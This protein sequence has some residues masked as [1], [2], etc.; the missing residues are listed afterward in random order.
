[1]TLTALEKLALSNIEPSKEERQSIAPGKHKVAFTVTVNGVL[2]VSAPESYIPTVDVP[3]IPTVA[4]ALKK[5]GVQRENFLAIMKESMTEVLACDKAMRV[6]LVA[7]SG[8]IDFEK[9]FRKTLGKLP[10][11]TRVGKVN[12]KLKATPKTDKVW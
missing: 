3:L 1:M 5:M 7:E 11:K 12:A 2:D 6:A 10:K 8:L 4:L 9:D